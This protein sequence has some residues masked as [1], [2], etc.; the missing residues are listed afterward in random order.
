MAIVD[1]ILCEKNQKSKMKEQVFST[2]DL[3]ISRTSSAAQS[4]D[5][6]RRGAD[7]F[8]SRYPRRFSVGVTGREA[9]QAGGCGC[10]CV[11]MGKFLVQ[12]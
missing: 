9:E 12:T 8:V 6:A 11:K 2:Y 10:G 4:K 7:A 5:H 1:G 3:S